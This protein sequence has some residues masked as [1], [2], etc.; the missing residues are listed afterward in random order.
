MKGINYLRGGG[1]HRR[2]NRRRPNLRAVRR[3]QACNGFAKIYKELV[4]PHHSVSRHSPWNRPDACP[5]A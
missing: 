5:I 4:E 3:P 2:A 1:C